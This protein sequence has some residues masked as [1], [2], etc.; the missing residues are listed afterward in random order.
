MT[1][2][3]Q[4]RDIPALK[5]TYRADKSSFD[6]LGLMSDSGCRESSHVKFLNSS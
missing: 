4:V 3:Y 6:N 1:G 5:D 2:I